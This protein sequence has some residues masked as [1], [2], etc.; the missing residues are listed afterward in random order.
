MQIFVSKTQA[1]SQL[2]VGYCFYVPATFFT[3]KVIN[4]PTKFP[5]IKSQAT[6]NKQLRY[7]KKPKVFHF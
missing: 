6:H 1:K 7:Y 5:K 3:K 4:S 2:R